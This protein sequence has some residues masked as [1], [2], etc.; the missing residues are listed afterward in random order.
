[1][2]PTLATKV[3]A[4]PTQPSVGASAARDAHHGTLFWLGLFIGGAMIGYGLRG[5]FDHEFTTR[6]TNLA[7]WAAGLVVFHDLVMAPTAFV[8]AA[9]ATRVRLLASPY[10]RAALATSVLLALVTWPLVR[11]YGRLRDNPTVL[12]LDYGANLIGAVVAIWIV[13][14][15]ATVRSNRCRR[16]EHRP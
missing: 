12:P 3:T 5:L 11:G 4:A 16:R 2:S 13:A 9:L 8:L 15:A 14:I 7:K 10:L 1:M 6:P